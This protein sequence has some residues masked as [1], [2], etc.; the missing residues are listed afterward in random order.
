MMD[1]DIIHEFGKHS[2][3]SE[4]FYFNFYDKS[5]D[6][7]GF[8]RIGL[9]PNKN[10]KSMFCFFMLPDGRYIGM[11]DQGIFTNTNLTV[12]ALQFTKIVPEK[13][14]QLTFSGH[15]K[16]FEGAKSSLEKTNFSLDFMS[17]NEIFNYRECV[18]GINEEIS[19]KVASEHLEQFGKIHGTL[20]VGDKTY[21]INGLGER[22]HS[23]GIRDWNAPKMWI[24]L[25]CQFSET[26]A[27]NITK[28]V[29][30]DGEVDA[31]F[32]HINGVNIPIITVDIHTDYTEDNCP[33]SF[34][35][36]LE[37]KKGTI[38]NVSAVIMKHIQLPFPNKDGENLSVMYET[39]TKYTLDKEIGYGIAEYLI[40]KL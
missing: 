33:Q 22:D 27:L 1:S 30:E 2:D 26:C 32:I 40:K 11:Q 12:N 6:I 37:D 34:E 38:H 36:I 4:S 35:M 15:M 10:E 20:L 16:T 8:M 21:T 9:K 13:H 7:C 19:R 3:W 23:W 18:S 5:K 31:G 17:L 39:L 28:L 25:T 29:T 24:W 14:W